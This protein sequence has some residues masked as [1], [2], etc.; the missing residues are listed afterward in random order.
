[1]FVA[2]LALNLP[3]TEFGNLVNIWGSYGQ[4]FSVLFFDS[5][6]SLASAFSDFDISTSGNDS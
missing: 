5:R 1:M 3:V 6:C 4:E 2:N